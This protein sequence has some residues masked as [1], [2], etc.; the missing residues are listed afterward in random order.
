MALTKARLSL[1]VLVTTFIGFWA[2]SRSLGKFDW[3]LLVHNFALLAMI[4]GVFFFFGWTAFSRRDFK[5]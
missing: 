3:W 5:S 1:M 4:C 2:A